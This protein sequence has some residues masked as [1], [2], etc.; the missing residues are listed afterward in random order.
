[1]VRTV[2]PTGYSLSIAE[3]DFGDP[4]GFASARPIGARTIN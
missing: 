3:E 4:M 2:L 1:M